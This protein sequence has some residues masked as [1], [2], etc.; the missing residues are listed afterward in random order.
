MEQNIWYEMYKMDA[1]L[2]D[3]ERIDVKTAA[4]WFN[5]RLN[6]EMTAEK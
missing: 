1:V 2:E 3:L 5:Q 6:K 4:K